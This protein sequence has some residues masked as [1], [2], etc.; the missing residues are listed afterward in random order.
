MKFF[1]VVFFFPEMV[2][3]MPII[4][5]EALIVRSTK[6]AGT[7]TDR[8]SQIAVSLLEEYCKDDHIQTMKTISDNHCPKDMTNAQK[9]RMA[10]LMLHKLGNAIFYFSEVKIIHI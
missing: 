8:K 4:E 1:F 2:S 7:S 5:W 3:Q 9:Y 10:L 6:E